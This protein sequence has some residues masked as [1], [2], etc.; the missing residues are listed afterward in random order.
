MRWRLV[1]C[2]KDLLITFVEQSTYENNFY[3]EILLKFSDWVVSG[4]KY[5]EWCCLVLDVCKRL[6]LAD[7][8]CVY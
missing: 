4:G 1:C 3:K 8:G 2:L 5:I 6:S 7:K